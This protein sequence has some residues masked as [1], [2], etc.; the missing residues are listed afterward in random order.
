[1]LINTDNLQIDADNIL[2][3]VNL[4]R[5]YVYNPE[6]KEKELYQMM[7]KEIDKEKAKIIFRKRIKEEYTE[8]Y[9]MYIR[10]NYPSFLRIYN[11]DYRYIIDLLKKEDKW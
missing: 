9:K 8:R 11:Y 3:D 10:I 7:I 6:T 4:Y 5:T 1:M 2:N